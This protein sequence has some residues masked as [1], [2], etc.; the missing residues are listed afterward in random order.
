MAG[1]LMSIEIAELYKRILV[2]KDEPQ[3]VIR[4]GNSIEIIF[5]RYFL[6]RG[7]SLRKNISLEPKWQNI[8]QN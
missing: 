6:Y 8:H 7:R 1:K 5:R 3:E 2:C 4:I